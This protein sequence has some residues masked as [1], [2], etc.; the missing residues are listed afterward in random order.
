VP[1]TPD[2][3]RW[4]ESKLT[5]NAL[6]NVNFL[7]LTVRAFGKRIDRTLPQMSDNPTY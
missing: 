5:E 6:E 7:R 1:D 4:V 2:Q 3:R